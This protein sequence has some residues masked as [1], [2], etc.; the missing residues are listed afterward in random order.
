MYHVDHPPVVKSESDNLSSL[1]ILFL[2]ATLRAFHVT[3]HTRQTDRLTWKFWNRQAI[4]WALEELLFSGK[5]GCCE[6]W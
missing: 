2:S 4:G 3:E 1:F 6:P 5:P